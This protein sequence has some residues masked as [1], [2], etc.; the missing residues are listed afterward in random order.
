MTRRD[1]VLTSTAAMTAA[2][3]ATP[4]RPSLCMFTKHMPKLNYD[5][6]GKTLK[7]M[8]FDG[9]DLTVRAGGH[10]LPE[11]AAEDM[12]RA[13]ETIRGHGI[14]VPMITTNLLDA[15]DPTARPILSTAARLK[16]PVFKIGYYQY[17]SPDIEGQLR[18]VKPR[19]AG[20]VALGKEQGIQVGLHNH[21][22]SYVGAAVWDIR[23]ILGDMDPH[24]IGYYFDPGHATAEGG[25]FGWQLSLQMAA[26]RIKM[27]A[28]KDF[29]F[30][31]VKGKW[32]L[33]W[34]PLGQG[35]VDWP[36]VFTILK[37]ANFAG[38][39]SLHS[40]YEGGETMESIAR[41]FAFMKKQV[42]A[43]WGS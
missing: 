34:C 37:G 19:V 10:V 35:M 42:D 29:Y 11:R 8:G 39:A 40:E 18:A 43:A 32:K 16:V 1:F 7:Q 22:G 26:P 4:Q 28:I 20:L 14:A 24:W 21:S 13:V 5:E 25:V 3:A 33:Q 15:S 2:A 17:K 9:A 6:L 36:K 30:E 38:P 27:I 12:P 31:K 41:D 23:T